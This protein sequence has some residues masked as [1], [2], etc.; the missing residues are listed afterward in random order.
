MNRAAYRLFLLILLLFSLPVRFEPACSDPLPN[1]SSVTARFFGDIDE[2]LPAL[3]AEPPVWET[4]MRRDFS[5]LDVSSGTMTGCPA[6]IFLV[7]DNIVFWIDEAYPGEVPENIIREL[8][9]FE[10]GRLPIL[11]GIF[12]HEASP[13]VDNDPRVHVLFTALIGDGYNGYFS[14]ED[15]ADPRLRPNSNS[16]ELVFLHTKLF[17]QGSAAVIDTLSHEFQ[18]M[19]HYAYDPNEMS[20]INEGFS[21]LAEY[22]AADYVR[23]P[24]LRAYLNDTGRSLI[25]WPDS[26]NHTPYYGSSFLF[27]VYL[28]D[29]F[30][31]E[32]IRTMTASEE[33]GLD[34]LDDALKTCGIAL[35]AEDVFL[36][37]AAALLG[38]LLQAPVPE[39]DYSGYAFPQDGITRDI[40]TLSVS[41]PETH[42]TAQYGLRFYR[43]EEGM[44]VRIR[45]TGDRESPVTVLA[46]PGGQSA[47]WSGAESDS[48]AY[49]RRD[50]D[51]SGVSGEVFFEY[52]ASFD[53]EKDYDYYYLLIKDASGKI[54]RLAPS[55]ATNTNPAGQNMGNG[56]TGSSGGTL[57]ETIDLSP[58]AGQPVR[59]T[60]VY[61]TDTAGVSDGLLLDNFRITAIGF[62][63]DAENDREGWEAAGF[64]RI[65]PVLPQRWALAVLHPRK[66]GTSSAE[67]SFFDGGETF[68][69]DCPEGGCTFAISAVRREVR[70]RAAFTIEAEA[71]PE[72]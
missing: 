10:S 67:L 20:F 12:G 11:H 45:V 50:F 27:S 22:T 46:I 1:E 43:T 25:W 29:R 16:M 63:D 62:E 19:I 37:W 2:D 60:F 56:T 55:T 9:N 61:L 5:V 42:E 72:P 53:I 36:Q 4:G 47:W 66:D 15:S 26:G 59:L 39:L 24:F 31:P 14:A 28:F 40:Q 21:G 71:L 3:T 8:E 7:T 34:G 33:N 51:L 65:G 6:R 30:G 32:L 58:W 17:N 13:G 64:R 18:H 70:T 49:L 69:A 41:A 38:Q 48:L 52:D 68:S 54:T 57:H 44:P 23:E 35:G